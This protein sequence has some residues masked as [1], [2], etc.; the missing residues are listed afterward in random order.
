VGFLMNLRIAGTLV[1]IGLALTACG[2]GS[3]SKSV[4]QPAVPP[5]PVVSV[6]PTPTPEPGSKGIIAW[7]VSTL[8]VY[9]PVTKQSNNRAFAVPGMPVGTAGC[10]FMPRGGNNSVRQSYSP[11]FGK[12][13]W[14]SGSSA[15]GSTASIGYVDISSGVVHNLTPEKSSSYG[16]QSPRQ[17]LPIFNPKTGDLWLYDFN[18]KSFMSIDLSNPGQ[19][20]QKR[21]DPM[22]YPAGSAATMNGVVVGKSPTPAIFDSSPISFSAD[23]SSFL[24][25]TDGVSRI[26]AL[27]NGKTAIID[28]NQIGY[29]IS[30]DES[31]LILQKGDGPPPVAGEDPLAWPARNNVTLKWAPGT[32][33]SGCSPDGI[34]FIDSSS[35]LCSGIPFKLS[36]VEGSHPH[37]LYR[38]T[39]NGSTLTPTQ[40]TP[41]S[42]NG[43]KSYVV[44][45]DKQ[46]VAFVADVPGEGDVLF[47]VPLKGGEPTKIG[48][49]T[50][51]MLIDWK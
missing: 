39:I 28:K 22:G 13:T 26:S 19:V 43:V 30:A 24:I 44:S 16:A 37:N 36:S 3:S 9:D 33:L 45:P 46:S 34:V 15:E 21:S 25:I 31:N 8:I 42:E 1:G 12:A 48:S 17:G 32:A 50:G 2:G 47:T 6:T 38:V 23:G 35:F 18:L 14:C 29:P 27:P 51:T 7:S 49:F 40:V 10:D 5:S 20:P 11:D 41:D 4:A